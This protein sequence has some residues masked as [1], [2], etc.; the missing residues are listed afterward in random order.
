MICPICKQETEFTHAPDGRC[1][2]CAEDYGCECGCYPPAHQVKF[3]LALNPDATIELDDSEH[4][5]YGED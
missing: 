2:C 4:W 1:D 3:A 5:T